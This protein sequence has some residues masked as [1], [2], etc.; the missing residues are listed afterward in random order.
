MRLVCK[1]NVPFDYRFIREKFNQNFQHFVSGSL[2]NLVKIETSNDKKF[3]RRS[4]FSLAG[5]KQIESEYVS[6]YN[7]ESVISIV[8]EFIKL[9]IGIQNMRH[10]QKIRIHD[11]ESCDI[12]EEISFSTQKKWLKLVYKPVI[13]FVLKRR[14]NHSKRYFEHSTNNQ[15]RAALKGVRRAIPHAGYSIQFK[16][17]ISN[18]DPVLSRF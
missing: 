14:L 6:V 4:S 11:N 3:G 10:Y 17:K 8:S 16:T 12:F 2:G 5:S 18:A 15:E 9:P 13:L 7:N 1:S